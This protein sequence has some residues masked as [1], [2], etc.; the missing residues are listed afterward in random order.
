MEAKVPPLSS[1]TSSG[2]ESMKNVARSNWA[3]ARKLVL[4]LGL[5]LPHSG[6][7]GSAESLPFPEPTQLNPCGPESSGPATP[8]SNSLPQDQHVGGIDVVIETVLGEIKA[9]HPTFS[10]DLTGIE[11]AGSTMEMRDILSIRFPSHK[12]QRQPREQ[13]LLRNG[14]LWRGELKRDVDP[15]GDTI[16]WQSPSLPAPMRISL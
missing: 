15:N 1:K 12:L 14:T 7:H 2:R 11:V 4:S 9:P 10:G 3:T 5:I 6:L 16:L 13:I 8:R